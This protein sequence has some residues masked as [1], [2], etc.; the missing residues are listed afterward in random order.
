MMRFSIIVPVY[1]TVDYLEDCISSV[2]NQSFTDWEMIM[3]DDGSNDGSEKKIEAYSKK[4][5]R[6]RVCHQQ[7]SGQFFARQKGLEMAQGEYVLF[8]DSDDQYVSGALKIIDKYIQT[9]CPDILLYAG[10]IVEDGVRTNRCIGQIVP[11]EQQISSQCFKESLISSND[12]NSLYLKAFKRELF[13]GDPTDYSLFKGICY[14]EDKARLL[15]PLTIAELIYY[16]PDRLYLYRYYRGSTMH[17]YEVHMIPHM[18]VNDLFRLLEDYMEIWEM[19]DDYYRN[20]LSVYYLKNYLSVYF[21]FRRVCHSLPERRI[22]HQ[23]DWKKQ[24]NKDFFH[25]RFIHMLSLK[26]RI[27]L[28]IAVLRL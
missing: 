14:G 7:N 8:L 5:E 2:I 10:E 24:L 22:L 23:Y 25:Y 26:D 3:V 6:I 15:Y 18:L 17:R 19:N 13:D 9:N 1:N 12:M 16:I 27:K 20:M 11:T 4:D 28:L 21:G